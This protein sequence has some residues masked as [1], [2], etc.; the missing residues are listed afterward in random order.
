MRSASAWE[1]VPA[2]V[3]RLCDRTLPRILAC[4]AISHTV[5][6]PVSVLIDLCTA[7]AHPVSRRHLQIRMSILL[8]YMLGKSQLLV[9]LHK[10][11]AHTSLKALYA[12]IQALFAPLAAAASAV[13]ASVVWMLQPFVTAVKVVYS[14]LLGPLGRLVLLLLRLVWQLLQLLLWS[15]P[16]QLLQALANCLLAVGQLV[17]YP[18]QLLLP[19]VSGIKAGWAAAKATG[20]VARSA[21][22]AVVKGSKGQWSLIKW[23][24]SPWRRLTWCELSTVR[25]VKALQAVVRFFV[26]LGSTI[27]QHRLSLMLQLRQQLRGGLRAAADSPAGRRCKCSGGQA[28]PGGAGAAAAAAAAP[29]GQQFDQVRGVNSC[30]ILLSVLTVQTTLMDGRF[31]SC[32]EP[33]HGR[34][35]RG[36]GGACCCCVPRPT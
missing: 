36:G 22:P 12:P 21:A 14:V 19:S 4:T 26:A 20:Q 25:I 34:D 17:L 5:E 28:W 10:L 35:T 23:L 7:G 6:P 33:R 27:N 18:V 31:G 2:F 30:Q 1:P 13:A 8:T 32:S 11:L 24:W 3:R 16:L 9:Q 29:P 15:G